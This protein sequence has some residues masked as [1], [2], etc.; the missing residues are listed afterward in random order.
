MRIRPKLPRA[1]WNI[2]GYPLLSSTTFLGRRARSRSGPLDGPT[3][4]CLLS[5]EYRRALATSY[6]FLLFHFFSLAKHMYVKDLRGVPRI[7]A[8]LHSAARAGEIHQRSNDDEA[9]VFSSSSW[10]PVRSCT[11]CEEYFFGSGLFVFFSFIFWAA[12]A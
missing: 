6:P 2:A 7:S 5:R 9:V 11:L 3:L 12:R 4:V 8:R 10:T 1:H